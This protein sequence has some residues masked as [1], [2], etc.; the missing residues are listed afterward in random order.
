MVGQSAECR[1]SERS[2]CWVSGYYTVT[3]FWLQI[4]Y[5]YVLVRESFV[6]GSCWVEGLPLNEA[7]ILGKIKLFINV[8]NLNYNL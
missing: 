1:Q 3:V 2:S 7:K 6:N 8:I 4:P 5:C